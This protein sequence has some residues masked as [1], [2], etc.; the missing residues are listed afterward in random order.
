MFY[1]TYLG[2]SNSDIAESIAVDRAGS[3]YIAGQTESTNFPTQNPLQ[4]AY[5]GIN[6]AFITKLNPD[7]DALVY[8]TFLGGSG[9]NVALDVAVNRTGNAYITGYTNSTNFPIQNPLQAAYSDLKQE[10]THSNYL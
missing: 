10:R 6:D 1:S 2:G 3:A 8:S 9:I 5:G 4:P 7:G